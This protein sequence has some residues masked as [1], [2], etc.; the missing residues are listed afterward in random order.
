MNST[1]KRLIRALAAS[2]AIAAWLAALPADAV[3]VHRYT[4]NN[5]NTND[6][7][8]TAHGTVVDGGTPTAVF[9]LDGQLD[10][11]ANTGQASN[12]APLTDAYVDLPNGMISAAA[13]SGT[14]GALSVEWWFTVATTRT[15]QRLGD[16]A[17]PLAGGGGEDANN[18]GDV[19]YMLITPNSG[20]LNNGVEMS[21]NTTGVVENT[22]GQG[23]TNPALAPGVQHHVVAVYDKNNTSGGANPGGT[24]SLFFNGVEIVPGGA[25]VAGSNAIDPA[26]DLNNLNDH[27][28]WLGRSQWGGDPMYDGS[29]N[30]FNVYDH[31]LNA[32]EAAANFATGPVPVPLPTLIVNTTTGAAAIKNNLAGPVTIDYYEVTSASGKLNPTSWNSLSDQNIDAG[33][34]ADF[35]GNA[36]VNGQDLEAWRAGYG[37]GT[38]KAQGNAD[39]DGDVD[40]NDF[41]LWQRQVGTTAGEGDSWDEAGGSSSN[42]LAE[43]F[44]NGATTLAPGQQIS[45]GNAYVPGAGGDLVFRFAIQ[46]QDILTGGLVQYVTSGPATGVPEPGTACL[47][48]LGLAAWAGRRQSRGELE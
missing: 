42:Q 4:F 10:L 35:N 18:Q 8:G 44:L 29:F 2:A 45:L 30:E 23:G 37:T 25:N 41:L 48:A 17:G 21:N 5:G 33:L 14:S 46:G 22:F 27:D 16:F 34:S 39:G 19:N 3:L 43:L 7:V 26:F 1:V 13:Q 20:R 15:W 6:S 11:S 12:A 32:T 31:A 36:A 40:G 28:N 24:M 38:T 47:L 9:S